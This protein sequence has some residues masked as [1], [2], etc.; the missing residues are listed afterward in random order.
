MADTF[1]FLN[2]WEHNLTT[3]KVLIVSCWVALKEMDKNLK[4]VYTPDRGARAL[5]LA[6]ATAR[7]FC[8]GEIEKSRC[9]I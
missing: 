4:K 9:V 3:G 7:E 1:G 6:A 2:K 8:W 5:R